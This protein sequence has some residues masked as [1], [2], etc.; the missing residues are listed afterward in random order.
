MQKNNSFYLD[1]DSFTRHC[2]IMGS[3]GS[4]KTNTIIKMLLSIH[5]RNERNEKGEKIPFL[6]IEPVKKDYRHLL[7]YIPDLEIYSA[8]ST[9][10]PLKINLFEVPSFLSYQQWVNELVGIIS[11]SFY[12]WQPLREII[13]N[14]LNDLYQFKGW[15]EKKRGIT[16]TLEEFLRF[17]KL[18]I[19]CLDYSAE[20]RDGYKGAIDVRFSSLI[21][22]TRGLIF[23]VHSSN[24]SF[25]DLMEKPIVIELDE[26]RNDDERALVFN[27]LITKLYLYQQHKG[28][29][30]KLRHLTV[31]EEAH[32][33]I[34]SQDRVKDAA[35]HST[36]MKAQERFSDLLS[37]IRAYGEGFIISEQKT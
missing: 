33:L 15:T 4:G 20:T 24:P 32:R 18:S 9:I 23:N 12:I 37:E 34:S 7:H 14:A 25:E 13:L 16:P 11:I 21:T 31:I 22:G 28:I 36:K 10:N 35:D 27:F 5:E 2:L 17:I 8:G 29:S 6:I 19:D 26:L 1:I 3:T 30:N